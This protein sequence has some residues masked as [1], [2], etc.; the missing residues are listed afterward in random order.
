MG[1]KSKPR[2]PDCFSRCRSSLISLRSRRPI[3]RRTLSFAA[4]R[5]TAI[6][7]QSESGRWQKLTPT[8]DYTDAGQCRLYHYEHVAATGAGG[9]HG[10]QSRH[11]TGR[12]NDDVYGTFTGTGQPSNVLVL[13]LIKPKSLLPQYTAGMA[14][15]D[16]KYLCSRGARHKTSRV[17]TQHLLQPSRSKLRSI[18][19]PG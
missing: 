17:S 4:T 1:H 10:V 2:R 9:R 16:E 8:K 7:G 12:A 5:V 14:D 11:A 3:Q 13:K 6:P 15:A 18:I 19:S